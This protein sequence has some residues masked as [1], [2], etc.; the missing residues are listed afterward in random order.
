MTLVKRIGGAVAIAAA[1]MFGGGLPAPLAQAAYFLS[2]QQ[3]GSDVFAIGAGTI[4][5]TD[6]V[7]EARGVPRLG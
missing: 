1:M 2:L 5:L 6:L 7:A 3:H 4:D